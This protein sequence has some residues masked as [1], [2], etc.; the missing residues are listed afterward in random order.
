MRL[1]TIKA[2]SHSTPF[3]ETKS[4]TITVIKLKVVKFDVKL[5]F[6]AIRNER[7]MNV[8]WMFLDSLKL[9]L[10]LSQSLLIL[11]SNMAVLRANC[12]QN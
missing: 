5:D 4:N 10:K 12:M 8:G 2:C 1:N 6:N 7:K 9:K 11:Y 3:D